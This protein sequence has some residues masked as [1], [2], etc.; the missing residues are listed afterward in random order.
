MRVF[1]IIKKKR[2]GE[3]LKKEEIDFFISSYAR[4]DIP[5][6]QAAAFCMAV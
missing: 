4:G 2:D 5:D 3:V 1:D 6:Y